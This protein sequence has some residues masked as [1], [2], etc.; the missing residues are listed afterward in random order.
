VVGHDAIIPQLKEEESPWQLVAVE[1][2][3]VPG[4]L[5]WFL[6]FQMV[7]TIVGLARDQQELQ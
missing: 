6:D 7:P 2:D 4:L 3:F 5:H 1:L